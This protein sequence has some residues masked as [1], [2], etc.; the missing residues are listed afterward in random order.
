MSRFLRT[1]IAAGFMAAS[2]GLAPT[3]TAQPVTPDF[4]DDTSRWAN[5]GECDDP[6]F[7]GTG[8]SE[9]TSLNDDIGHDAT[10]CSAAW[11][12]GKLQLAD[13]SDEA[14]PDFGDDASQFA[15]DDECDDPRFA[16]PGMTKTRLLDDDIAHDAADCRTAF[17]AGNIWLIGDWGEDK[18]D[19]GDD[20][21]EWANDGECDDP[22]FTGTGMTKTTLKQE[23]I[24]HDATD[25]RTALEAGTITA[26]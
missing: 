17:E 26:R 23:D 4:G 15:S 24:L 2:T 12:G 21:G 18:L 14:A 19:F 1:L 16:G 22:R 6:R 5:D 10:D 13:A 3:S 9:G 8:M 11:R 25:C 7:V 20:D